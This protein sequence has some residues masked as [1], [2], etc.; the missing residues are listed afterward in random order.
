V[1]TAGT[2]ELSLTDNVASRTVHV[3]SPMLFVNRHFTWPN[4]ASGVGDVQF[5]YEL[6][7]DAA[8][9]Q[10]DIYDLTGQHLGTFDR[11]YDSAA[12]VAG[13]AGLLSGWNDLGWDALEESAGELASGVYIYRLAVW[14]RGAVEESDLVTGRFAIVR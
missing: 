12:G 11:S 14:D 4:P 6:S 8:A 13:N 7:R 9:V 2:D 1:T 10:L 5:R 3:S